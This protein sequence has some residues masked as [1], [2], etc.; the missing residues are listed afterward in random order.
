M[1]VKSI[2]ICTFFGHRDTSDKI[3]HKLESVLIDLIENYNIDSFY[4]GNNGNFDLIVKRK[5]EE[6]SII[7]P[8]ISYTIVLAYMPKNKNSNNDFEKTIL[9]DGIEN[10]PPKFAI[11]YRNK[12]LIEKS[13]IVVTYVKRPFGGAATFKKMAEKKGKKIINIADEY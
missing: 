3:N 1:E 4:L 8:Q 5:L 7:Y 6:L 2:L 10:V 11:S 13:D 12:W 9:P